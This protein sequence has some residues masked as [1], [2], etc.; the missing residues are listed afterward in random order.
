MPDPAAYTRREKMTGAALTALAL[1]FVLAGVHAARRQGWF[2]RGLVLVA[3]FEQLN[4][5][6]TGTSVRMKGF[7]IGRVRHI[8]FNERNTFT[9]DFEIW[10]PYRDKIRR[11]TYATPAGFGADVYLDIVE[12]KKSDDLKNLR[13]EVGAL[14]ELQR[15]VQT[16]QGGGAFDPGAA[17]KSGERVWS[18]N[19]RPIFDIVSEY[20][21]E[22]AKKLEPIV[23][24]VEAGA[25]ELEVILANVNAVTQAMAKGE[26]TV[27][28]ILNDKELARGIKDSIT[29]LEAVMKNTQEIT[30]QVAFLSGDAPALLH[31]LQKTLD[32]TDKILQALKQSWLFRKR[33][34]R[35][36]EKEVIL[37]IGR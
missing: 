12:V 33:F 1:A 6:K 28:T 36:A 23:K 7:T 37:N 5:L 2:E 16:L 4:N 26:G 20:L 14:E 32:D 30:E 3:E 17:W 19:P 34:R 29:S 18:N 27:A 35:Q 22:Q 31:S 9:V 10:K 13:L 21:Q 15:L 25:A 11:N 8:E 24:R